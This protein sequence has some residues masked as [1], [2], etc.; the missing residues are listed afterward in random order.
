MKDVMQQKVSGA[1]QAG[2]P[3]D[4]TQVLVFPAPF[5]LSHA[6]KERSLQVP[7]KHFFTS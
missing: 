1:V 5:T 2:L 4:V 7:L 6:I 3:Y